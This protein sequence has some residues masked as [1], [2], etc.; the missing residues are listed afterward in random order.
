MFTLA[1]ASFKNTWAAIPIVPAIPAPERVMSATLLTAVTALTRFWSLL[2]VSTIVVPAP[3]GLKVFFTR[4]GIPLVT[5]GSIVF[6]CITFA[7]K[8][9]ISMSLIHISEPTRLRRISY[10]VFC[11]KK[12]NIIIALSTCHMTYNYESATNTYNKKKQ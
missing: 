3:L 11:L 6:G 9:E 8:Y 7:P 4:T 5:A 2:T 1:L 12:K 10:A